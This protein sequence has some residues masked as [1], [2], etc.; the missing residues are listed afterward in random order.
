MALLPL[1]SIG[2][3]M[4][5]WLSSSE[6]ETGDGA[7]ERRIQLREYEVDKNEEPM[8]VSQ[9]RAA[10]VRYSESVLG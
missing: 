10:A 3:E 5:L 7:G 6:V 8:P 2:Q 9:A 4:I 1:V